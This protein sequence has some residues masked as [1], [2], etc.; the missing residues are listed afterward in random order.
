MIVL[1]V[2]AA[3]VVAAP[4]GAAVLVTVASHYEDAARTLARRPP[5]PLA[6]AARSLVCLRIGGTAYQ[7]R[8]GRRSDPMPEPEAGH[9]ASGDTPPL[10]LSRR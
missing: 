5:G 7:R 3:V 9:K 6:A 8:Q 1:L 2:V 10:T 4:L